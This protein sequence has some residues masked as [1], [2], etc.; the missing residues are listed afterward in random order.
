MQEPSL[1]KTWRRRSKDA[2]ESDPVERDQVCRALLQICEEE[3][4]HEQNVLVVAK[5]CAIM[6]SPCGQPIA[7]EADEG[8]CGTDGQRGKHA[9]RN[10]AVPE[11]RRHWDEAVWLRVVG[12]SVHFDLWNIRR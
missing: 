9:N 11:Y 10:E 12:C 5:K 2:I 4:E 7:D 1:S 3:V 8:E 6:G